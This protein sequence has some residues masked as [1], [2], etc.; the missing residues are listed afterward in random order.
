[1]KKVSRVCARALAVMVA[2]MMLL[3]VS[4]L[5]DAVAATPAT[6][7][8]HEPVSYFVPGSRIR[9][10]AAV[11]DKAGVKLV[12]CYFKTKEQA[13]FVFVGLSDIGHGLY[14][15]I[16]PAPSKNTQAIIYLFLAVASGQPVKT[17]EFRM[18]KGGS[19][20]VP[21]W[22]Q[23]SAE[24]D[25]RVSMELP[26]MTEPPEGF[27][28]SIV[29]DVVESSARFGVVAG[30]YAG[31]QSATAGAAVGASAA[32]GTT[33]TTAT[34][35]TAAGAAG[36]GA[37]LSTAAIVGISLGGAAAVGGGVL[38]L[39]SSDDS[40]GSSRPTVTSSP[41][42]AIAPGESFSIEFSEAM[43][44]QAGTIFADPTW[45]YRDHWGGDHRTLVIQL[46]G[47]AGVVNFSL[48]GFKDAGGNLLNPDP[49]PFTVEV[50]DTG[51]VRIG[52]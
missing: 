21:D 40:S 23:V 35:A 48:Q 41:P 15:G 19:P 20:R 46:S 34:T 42:S 32:T 17:G 5:G 31:I 49:Y 4:G 37:G 51:G 14:Q 24:G 22:Q 18:M 25:I 28:D 26:E 44:T 16:L 33:A 8:S 38:L 39:D 6:Q 52:W 12:R 30:L 2:G 3:P 7:I 36:T 29:M 9:V 45:A 27:N 47:Q 1:M 10:E 50:S 11:T 13:N 43:D